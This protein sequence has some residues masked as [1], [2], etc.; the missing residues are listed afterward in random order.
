METIFKFSNIGEKNLIYP[1][2]T[3]ATLR[4]RS[5]SRLRRRPNLCPKFKGNYLQLIPISQC[6][7]YLGC[8]FSG[9]KSNSFNIK[10]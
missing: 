8:V 10:S 3:A 2:K 1:I 7:A 5:Y 9:G 4:N 6:T